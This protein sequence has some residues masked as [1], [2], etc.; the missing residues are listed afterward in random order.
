MRSEQPGSPFTGTTAKAETA[1][2]AAALPVHFTDVSKRFG[3]RQILDQAALELTPGRCH[4][5]LGDNGAGK[6]TLMRIMAGLLKPERAS[7]DWGAGPRSWRAGRR[8]LQETVVYLHQ[9]PYLFDASMRANIA[10]AIPKTM[11][12]Q[13]REDRV[14]QALAWA[15]L[16]GLGDAHANYLSGGERQRLALARAWA[17]GVPVLLLDEPASAMDA[18]ARRRFYRLLE[19]LVEQGRTLLLATHDPGNFLGLSPLVMKL[20]GGRIE[21][22]EAEAATTEVVVP[23]SRKVTANP[24]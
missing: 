13:E 14:R 24:R 11:K 4:L 17:R 20:E 22:L 10:Y 5:L 9:R 15:G 3:R 23:L 6:S 8:T 7:V 1:T 19:T 12:R 16:E 2:T 21:H 18:D